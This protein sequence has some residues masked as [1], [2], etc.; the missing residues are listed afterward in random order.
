MILSRELVLGSGSP[1]RKEILEK[2]GFEF[3]VEVRPTD[4]EFPADLSPELV[5]VYLAEKKL[6]AFGME[7]E[8]K[9]VLCSDTVVILHGEIMNKPADVAEAKEMLRALSGNRHT[10]VTGVALKTR[11]YQKSFADSCEVFFDELSEAEIDYYLKACK[12]FDKA[13]SYGIQD[14]I[15]MAGIS[16]LE[17]SFYTVMGLPVHAVYGHLKPFIS[18]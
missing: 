14:F 18:F 15:G 8:D 11:G 12:P 1:R 5:P 16:R 4:E 2:A 3:S 13:G 6:A 17:G 10:V 9:I 7:F